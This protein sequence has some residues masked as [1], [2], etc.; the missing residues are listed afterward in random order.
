MRLMFMRSQVHKAHFSTVLRIVRYVE[1]M[2]RRKH[3]KNLFTAT[4]TFITQF[5]GLH[6][7][8]ENDGKAVTVLQDQKKF[9]LVGTDFEN[10]KQN[11]TYCT[12]LEPAV[13]YY[14]NK[15]K[16]VSLYNTVQNHTSDT[17]MSVAK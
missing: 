17:R 11:R 12:A 10:A 4:S 6:Y 3:G 2:H 7:L 14:L 16:N 5:F 1:N 13:F 8:K 9:I 15:P